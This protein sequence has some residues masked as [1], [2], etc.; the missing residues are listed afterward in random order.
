MTLKSS[1]RLATSILTAVLIMGLLVPSFQN[2]ALQ[3]AFAAPLT[4]PAAQ[5]SSNFPS[6]AANYVV[7][8]TTATTGVVGK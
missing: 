7:Q 5:P 8:F 1:K 6:R 3:Q 4:S 2:F